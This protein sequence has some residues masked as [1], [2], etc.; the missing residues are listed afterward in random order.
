MFATGKPLKPSLLLVVD[1]AWSLPL[2]GAP[3]RCWT[4]VGFGL[5]S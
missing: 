3:E 4:W 1:K 2:S 5:Q